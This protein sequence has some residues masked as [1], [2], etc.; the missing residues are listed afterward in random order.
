MIQ[1]MKYLGHCCVAYMPLVPVFETFI[2]S[3][4]TVTD[5]KDMFICNPRFQVIWNIQAFISLPHQP[6]LLETMQFLHTIC[7]L[8]VF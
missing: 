2:Y 4:K 6:P 8:G 3:K 1:A 7:Y 5:I